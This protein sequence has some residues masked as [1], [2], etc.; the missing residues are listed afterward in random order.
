MNGKKIAFAGFAGG[1]LLFVL[2][3]GLNII[4][5]QIIAY[6]PAQF[7]GMRPMDD[8]VMVLFFAY[9]YVVSF[10]AAYLFDILQ[11]VLPAPV[12]QKGLAFGI[13]LIVILAIPSDF[14]MYT[15]MDWPITFYLGNLVW[16]VAGF[17]STGILFARIWNP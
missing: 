1:T 11:P 4:M 2:L 5:N 3:F 10:T 7:H 9:P 16:A 13:I 14:A 15:S 6:D 17:L 8:P 12:M